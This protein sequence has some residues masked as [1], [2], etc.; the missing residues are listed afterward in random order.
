MQFDNAHEL[1]GWG[2][3]ARYT[4]TCSAGAS[5][6]RA[7]FGCACALASNRSSSRRTDRNTRAASKT[8][9]VPAAGGVGRCVTGWFQSQLLQRRYA[10]PKLKRLQDTVNTQHAHR[11]LGGLTTA[12]SR[13]RR[14]LQL[15]PVHFSVHDPTDA[16]AAR[17]ESSCGPSP[18]LPRLTSSRRS[19]ASWTSSP[20]PGTFGSSANTVFAP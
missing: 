6:S 4:C 16:R 3:A 7:S 12:R 2:P 19:V 5:V 15:L 18:A 9:H 11:R 20:R 10:Q 8:A 13:R 1:V 14:I 17:A